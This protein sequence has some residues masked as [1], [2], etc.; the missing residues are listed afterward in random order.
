VR[1]KRLAEEIQLA[2]REKKQEEERRRQSES[3]QAPSKAAASKTGTVKLG[4]SD[5]VASAPYNT[6]GPSNTKRRSS[7]VRILKNASSAKSKSSTKMGRRV[8]SSFFFLMLAGGAWLVWQLEIGARSEKVRR[9][10]R[11]E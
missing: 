1:I 8:V 10:D 4:L 11:K 3:D 6:S 2:E 5:T 9:L 7:H